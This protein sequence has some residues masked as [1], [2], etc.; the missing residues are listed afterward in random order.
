MVGESGFDVGGVVFVEAVLL[1]AGDV[2]G[3]GGSGKEMLAQAGAILT[4]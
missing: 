3:A 4:L 2:E 1:E